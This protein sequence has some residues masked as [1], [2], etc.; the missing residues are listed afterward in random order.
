MIQGDSG[1]ELVSGS[2]E[3]TRGGKKTGYVVGEA[4]SGGGG[5]KVRKEGD[6]KPVWT[7]CL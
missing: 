3:L 2:P 6:R 5:S 7:H 1:K 4:G